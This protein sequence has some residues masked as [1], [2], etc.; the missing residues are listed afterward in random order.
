MATANELLFTAELAKVR[1]RIDDWDFFTTAE[2]R[3][4]DLR[5]FQDLVAVAAVYLAGNK[6]THVVAKLNDYVNGFQGWV[7]KGR[8]MSL[9]GD[10]MLRGIQEVQTLLN[11]PDDAVPL[12]DPLPAAKVEAVEKAVDKATTEP[13]KGERPWWV[14]PVAGAGVAYAGP[15]ILRLFLGSVLLV[16]LFTGCNSIAAFMGADVVT[17]NIA[18]AD[19]VRHKYTVQYV[20]A[21]TPLLEKLE[22]EAARKKWLEVGEKLKSISEKENK[23][24][25]GTWDE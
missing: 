4:T 9:I 23:L 7:S 25:Q 22:D 14:V 20:D 13:A 16:A 5:A 8:S 19:Q 6:K 10:R 3:D 15:K 24:I 12:Q 18:Q 1:V 17:D 2:T 21:T 11:L